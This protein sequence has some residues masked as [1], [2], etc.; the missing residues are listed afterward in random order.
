M[1]ALTKKDII[2]ECIIHTGVEKKT[3]S[4]GIETF[5][6]IIKDELKKGKDVSLS[7]FGKLSVREK[8]QRRGRNPQTGEEIAI[9]ARRSITFQLSKVL[10]TKLEE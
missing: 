5:I 3:A 1:E 10:R 9:K 4:E 8:R 7:G 2:D 6:D